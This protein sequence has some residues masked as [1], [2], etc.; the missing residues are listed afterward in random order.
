MVNRQKSDRHDRP[1]WDLTSV[2]YVFNPSIWNVSE[3][4][5][6]SI[7]ENGRNYFSA[8]KNG[9]HRYLEIPQNGKQKIIDDLVKRSLS[10]KPVCE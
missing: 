7:D 5:S 9:R 8:D 3:P 6:V 2:S 4:V 1:T 10:L